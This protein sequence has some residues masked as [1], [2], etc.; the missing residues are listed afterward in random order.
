MVGPKDP[1]KQIESELHVNWI[2]RVNVWDFEQQVYFKSIQRTPVAS[3]DV[4][5]SVILARVPAIIRTFS[6]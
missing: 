2:N 6:R 3:L 4:P 5:K 1:V